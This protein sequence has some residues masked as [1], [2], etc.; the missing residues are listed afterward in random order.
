[1]QGSREDNVQSGYKNHLHTT[2]CLL[3]LLELEIS[4]YENKI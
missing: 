1:M 4:Y 2:L 3:L